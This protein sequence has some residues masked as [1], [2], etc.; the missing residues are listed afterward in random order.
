MLAA[1]NAGEEA[2]ERLDAAKRGVRNHSIGIG[3]TAAHV[4][5]EPSDLGLPSCDL[6][7]MQQRLA[8]LRGEAEVARS[9]LESLVRATAARAGKTVRCAREHQLD[10]EPE[11]AAKVERVPKIAAAFEALQ[12]V[13]PVIG[14]LEVAANL[15]DALI[16][17]EEKHRMDPEYQAK[18]Q[19]LIEEIGNTL[20]TIAERTEDTEY[21][22]EHADGPVSVQKYLV[23][24]KPPR[25]MHTAT[26]GIAT[27]ERIETLYRRMWGEVARVVLAVEETVEK[28]GELESA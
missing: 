18:V 26:L 5:F 15:L 28:K 23:T 17:S 2:L 7:Q 14:S 8:E 11:L 21:P 12:R 16:K 9:D 13:W 27:L 10:L 1:V 6:D 4:E 19:A 24:E 25:D 22:Y 20:D 3:L